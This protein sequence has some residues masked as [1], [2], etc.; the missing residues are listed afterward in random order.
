MVYKAKDHAVMK[1]L[2]DKRQLSGTIQIDD[3][4]YVDELHS[5]KP[6]RGSEN[7]RPLLRRYPPMRKSIRSI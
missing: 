4:Y 5:G 2:D 3:V 6:G 7:K 1:E